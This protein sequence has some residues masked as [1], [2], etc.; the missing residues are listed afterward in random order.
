M[1]QSSNRFRPQNFTILIASADSLVSQSLAANLEAGGYHVSVLREKREILTAFNAE[2]FDLFI[3]DLSIDGAMGENLLSSLCENERFLSTPSIVL[4]D[5]GR[6]PTE[7]LTENKIKAKLVRKPVN[8][9]KISEDVTTILSHV[10]KPV[11]QKNMKVA[12]PKKNVYAVLIVE[13]EQSIRELLVRR[14]KKEGYATAEASN[15]HEALRKLKEREYDLVLLDIMMPEVD[16]YEV[17]NEI[18]KSNKL[19]NI[20]V[21]MITALNNIESVQQCMQ[22]GVDEYI[23][24]PFNFTDVREK[25]HGCLGIIR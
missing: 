18:K 16:G 22:S 17:L 6:E 13:D 11:G 3:L 15:G 10:M 9:G 24:K 21:I 8:I 25:I 4:A 1:T 20:P 7:L 23:V 19:Q 12:R 14:L 2:S 5:K